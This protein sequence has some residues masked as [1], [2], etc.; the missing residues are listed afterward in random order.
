MSLFDM[1]RTSE[2]S[3]R[4]YECSLSRTLASAKPTPPIYTDLPTSPGL[5]HP[6]SGTHSRA[7]S[8]LVLDTFAD[9]H[10]SYM[11]IMANHHPPLIVRR[12]PAYTLGS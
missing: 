1:A 8:P 4:G 9:A 10:V 6:A 3:E 12:K 5:N 2:R 11:V 7:A